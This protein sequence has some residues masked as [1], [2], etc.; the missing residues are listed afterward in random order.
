MYHLL[1]KQRQ[2][3]KRFSI[4]YFT[5]L[6]GHHIQSWVSPELGTQNCIWTFSTEGS[7]NLSE[8]LLSLRKLNTKKS[9]VV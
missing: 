9:V 7:E 3:R 2:D 6:K 5:P 8:H 4:H 1:E